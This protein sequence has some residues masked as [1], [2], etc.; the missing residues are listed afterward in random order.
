MRLHTWRY[1]V[2]TH[3]MNDS[4]NLHVSSLATSSSLKAT[5]SKRKCYN[6]VKSDDYWKERDLLPLWHELSLAAACCCK[7]FGKFFSMYA[8]RLCW[9]MMTPFEFICKMKTLYWVQ[10]HYI[11]HYWL[12]H[13]TSPNRSMVHFMIHWKLHGECWF[14]E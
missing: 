4:Y 12:K 8:R 11:I 2:V 1:V 6:K 13:L 10:I 9:S 14:F 3:L 7:D 5:K